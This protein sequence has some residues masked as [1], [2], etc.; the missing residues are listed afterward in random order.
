M[1]YL[2]KVPDFRKQYIENL[3][4]DLKIANVSIDYFNSNLKILDFNKKTIIISDRINFPVIVLILLELLKFNKL[5]VWLILWN[6]ERDKTISAFLFLNRIKSFILLE[7][8]V[9]FYPNFDDLKFMPIS[10][11]IVHKLIFDD[12][13]SDKIVF[14][15]ELFENL[16]DVLKNDDINEKSWFFANQLLSGDEIIENLGNFFEI[17]SYESWVTINRIRFLFLNQI[18]KDFHNLILIGD[19]FYK[20][21]FINVLPTN[22]LYNYRHSTFRN[23]LLNIDFLSKSTFAPMYPRSIECVSLNPNFLQ[24]KT[25]MFEN[26]FG[27]DNSSL[28]NFSSYIDLKNKILRL[29]ENKNHFSNSTLQIKFNNILSDSKEELFITN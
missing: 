18:Q 10:K 17:G 4:Y 19:D 14:I 20:L 12:F 7:L 2:V 11:P 25:Q 21:K 26:F 6:G 15:G 27:I 13:F 28:H 9:P 23:A 29:I 5:N 1:K 22:H 24:L 16:N 3:L 8:F